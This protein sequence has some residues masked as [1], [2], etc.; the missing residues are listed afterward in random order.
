VASAVPSLS[1]WP[2]VFSNPALAVWTSTLSPHPPTSPSLP[3]L[4]S[5]PLSL[6]HGRSIESGFDVVL[7]LFRHRLFFKPSCSSVSHSRPSLRIGHS[8]RTRTICTFKIRSPLPFLASPLPINHLSTTQSHR[9]PALSILSN[10]HPTQSPRLSSLTGQ[11][12]RA[13]SACRIILSSVL[14]WVGQF[15]FFLSF[16]LHPARLEN[17]PI[18]QLACTPALIPLFSPSAIGSGNCE[19]DHGHEEDGGSTRILA[20]LKPDCLQSARCR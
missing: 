8:K 12:R 20:L 9:V 13:S 16:F 7:S 19:D 1:R 15:P 17:L 18:L 10:L 4:P 2:V 6:H 3:P 14:F 5:C 11:P